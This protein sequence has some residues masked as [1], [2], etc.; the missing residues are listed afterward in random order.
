MTTT[1]TTTKKRRSIEQVDVAGKRVLMRVDFNVPLD[2]HGAITDDRRIRLALPSIRSVIE[3][4]G[5]LVLMSHLGRPKG[6]GFEPAL[7]LKPAA[8]HL[9]DLLGGAPVRFVEGDCAGPEATE[10]VESLA[11]GQVVVLDNLR[12]NPGEKSGDAALG[13]KLASFGDIYCHEAFGTSHRTDASMVATPVAMAGKPK[14][15]GFL[16]QKELRYLSEALADPERPFVAVL[17]GAKVSD[18]LGALRNLLGKVD[19][20][21]VGGAMAYTY[22]RALGH[23]VGASLVE[24]DMLGKAQEIIDEAAVAATDMILPHDHVCGKQVTH[25]T[26]VKVSET[27]IEEGWMG[28]DLGPGTVAQ[29][30]R[31][32]HQAR[33]IVWNGPVGVFETEPFDVGSRLIAAA[34]V[35]A[36]GL[37]AVTIIGGGDTAAAAEAFGLADRFSHVSTGGGASLQML[38]G[39]PLESVGL[40]DEA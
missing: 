33:T 5:R 2:E 9:G 38:E 8:V 19:T 26:P 6:K 13:A 18:K 21:L 10:A 16:L 36:T 27:S 15:A 35:G 11:D 24:L 30:V 22:I 32:I 34:M 3:R 23:D 20:I 40:L 17:G 14:V 4:N 28:L 7:S 12:F 37:G 31:L 39:R 25:V 1:T 29:Y